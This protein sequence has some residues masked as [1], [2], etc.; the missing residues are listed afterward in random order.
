MS[1][2]IIRPRKVEGQATRRWFKQALGLLGRHTGIWAVT[3]FLISAVSM[4][5]GRHWLHV[6]T[7]YLLLQIVFVLA[8]ATDQFGSFDEVLSALGK[9]VVAIFRCTFLWCIPNIALVS[10]ITG[11]V[12]GSGHAFD[13]AETPAYMQG[14]TELFLPAAGTALRWCLYWI[15]IVILFVIPMWVMGAGL[16]AACAL[17]LQGGFLNIKP[18]L[19]TGMLMFLIGVGLV[20][21]GASY[22][23]PILIGFIGCV[24]YVAWRDIYLGQAESKVHARQA[25]ESRVLKPIEAL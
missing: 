16:G 11:T 3:I 22:L 9:K 13:W 21:L 19:I 4:L 12:N 10:I 8:M 14:I 17:S 1:S 23:S 15:V 20:L 2:G 24:Q 6:W 18:L 25:Q 5:V 7:D